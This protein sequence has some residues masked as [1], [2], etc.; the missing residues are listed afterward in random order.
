MG[1]GVMKTIDASIGVANKMRDSILLKRTNYLVK[2]YADLSKGD[3]QSLNVYSD[4]S[5]VGTQ[6]L[7]WGEK[8][9]IKC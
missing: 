9:C 6:A 8:S 7:T 5:Y 2:K 1:Y 4:D 3:K